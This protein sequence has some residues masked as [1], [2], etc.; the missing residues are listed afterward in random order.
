MVQHICAP[1]LI[2]IPFHFLQIILGVKAQLSA[3]PSLVDV[4]IPEVCV[5]VL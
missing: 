1:V 4:T 2:D 3:L 5:L